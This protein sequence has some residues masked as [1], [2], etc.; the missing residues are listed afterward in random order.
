[1]ILTCLFNFCVC[2]SP[3]K[4]IAKA[5]ST[6]N[7]RGSKSAR[8]G[9]TKKARAKHQGK[10]NKAPASIERCGCKLITDDFMRYENPSWNANPL[11]AGKFCLINEEGCL[12][13]DTCLVITDITPVYICKKHTY[14]QN[15]RCV[16]S[17]VC[18]ACWEKMQP[19]KR[20]RKRKERA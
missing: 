18:I 15:H 20:S 8:N 14:K 2:D 13:R 17:H 16:A 12:A 11:L 9:K 3:Q 7:L 10:T 6:K 1:M 19:S 5:A 4:S